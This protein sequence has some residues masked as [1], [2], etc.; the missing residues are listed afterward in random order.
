MR[1]LTEP[2][3]EEV[4]AILKKH[5]LTREAAAAMLYVSIH[6]VDSWTAVPG[7]KQRKMPLASWELLLLKLDEH[8]FKI[9]RDR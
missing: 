7:P 6:T 5:R 1:T 9:V 2:T 3:N 8:P 4:R